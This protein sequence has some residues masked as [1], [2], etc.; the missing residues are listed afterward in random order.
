MLRTTTLLIVMVLTGGPT[1]S[2]VCELWCSAPAAADHHREVG[3]HDAFTSAPKSQ[4]I[5]AAGDCHD[6]VAVAPYVTE[7]RAAQSESAAT[8]PAVPQ[9]GSMAPDIARIAAGWGVLQV[10]PPGGPPPQTVLRI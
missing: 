3:C 8:Q 10:H 1:S 2:L 9:L 5:G 6:A 4:Q 7:A